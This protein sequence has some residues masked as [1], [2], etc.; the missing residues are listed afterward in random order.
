MKPTKQT[1]SE[2]QDAYDFFNKAL[3]SNQLPPC[4]ITL[5][6]HKKSYGY[7]S[8]EKFVHVGGKRTDEIA[9]NPAYFP[10][11]P[12]E[13][14]MQT[15]VHEMCHLWQ[16]HFGKPGRGAYHNKEWA[17]KMESIGL[18][19]SST[20][21][22][23]G[24]KTGDHVADY[25]IEEGLFIKKYRSLFSGDFQISWMDRFP[26][27]DKLVQAIGDGIVSEAIN[28][29]TH[30]ELAELG[31]SVDNEGIIQVLQEDRSNRQKY[32]CPDC[33]V[34]VWGKP[35]LKINCEDCDCSFEAIYV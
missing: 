13:E 21:K 30:E 20:G 17:E 22:A 25:F 10:V 2:L 28:I 7:F 23:G 8:F 4:L 18:M 9:L 3:F 15:L 32:T 12:P 29:E 14:I 26:I 11:C 33:K 1:Y 6:R 34:N 35:F 5:Q 24:K 16:F 27:R 31:L 19:P